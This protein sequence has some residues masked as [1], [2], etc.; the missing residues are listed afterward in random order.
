MVTVRYQVFKKILVI[1]G[2]EKRLLTDIGQESEEK[3]DIQALSR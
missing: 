3:K 2:Y 1:N